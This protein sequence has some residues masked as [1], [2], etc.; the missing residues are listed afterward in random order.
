[1]AVNNDDCSKIKTIIREGSTYT[2]KGFFYC[3]VGHDNCF[4]R[5]GKFSYLPL[6]ISRLIAKGNKANRLRPRH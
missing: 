2:W 3:R 5:G 1:M 4:G 6:F